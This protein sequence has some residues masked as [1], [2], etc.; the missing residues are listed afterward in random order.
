M[1]YSAEK[2]VTKCHVFREGAIALPPQAVS[3]HWQN[4]TN[5]LCRCG[6]MVDTH[7]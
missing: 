6:G 2:K 1:W 4:R 7:A 5:H 3:Q